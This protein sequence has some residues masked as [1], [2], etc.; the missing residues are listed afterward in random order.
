MRHCWL[1][2]EDFPEGTRMVID[3]GG[4]NLCVPCSKTPI[5]LKQCESERDYERRIIGTGGKRRSPGQR[6]EDALKYWMRGG[7]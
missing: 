7:R 2:R 3:R 1:C 6:S 4:A 5:G